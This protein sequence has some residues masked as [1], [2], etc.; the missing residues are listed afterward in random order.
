MAF[1]IGTAVQRDRLR[2]L[3]PLGVLLLYLGANS[4][5]RTSGGRYLVPVDWILIAYF[6]IALA[7]IARAATAALAQPAGAHV[8]SPRKARAREAGGSADAS[9]RSRRPYRMTGAGHPVAVLAYVLM[10][11]GLVPLAG[12][13]LPKRYHFNRG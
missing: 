3:V 12:V 2:G 8:R 9:D 1:G 13:L 4:L 11:G 6:S 10:I 5:A 7:E